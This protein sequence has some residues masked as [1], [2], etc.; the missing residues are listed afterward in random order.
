MPSET[1]PTTQPSAQTTTPPAPIKRR[2]RPKKRNPEDCNIDIILFIGYD[3]TGLRIY[4]PIGTASDKLRA[5]LLDAIKTA[6]CDTKERRSAYD[7]LVAMHNRQESVDRNQCVNM[8]LYTCRATLDP[9]SLYACA[10]YCRAGRVCA[11]VL[12]NGHGLKLCVYPGAASS[13][14]TWEEERSWVSE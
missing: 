13:K 2:G 8:W 14:S 7:N 3:E 9:H 1:A 11:R 4:K 5:F 12:N 6:Y 10:Q